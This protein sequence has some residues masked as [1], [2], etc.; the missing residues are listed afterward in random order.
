MRIG[1]L[2]D[3]HANLEALS[4]VLRELERSRVDQ[5]VCLGDVV[6]YHAN[7]NECVELLARSG[8]LTLAGNHDR[9]A[10]GGLDPEYFGAVAKRALFWTRR[11][12]SPEHARRLAELRVFGWLDRRTCLVHAALHPV[13]NDRYHLST[14]TRVAASFAK[15]HSGEIP[16][17]L[18]FFGH[19]HRPCVQASDG[20]H[21]REI[22]I[23]PSP[24]PLDLDSGYYL[25]NPG[26]VGQPR[27]GD[28]RAA[29]AVF[30]DAAG[31]LEFKSASYDH[32]LCL[33]KAEAAG[34]LA[35]VRPGW[36]RLLRVFGSR[37][38]E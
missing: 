12:L 13:P 23:G 5:V 20:R 37:K 26:S 31:T 1:L 34:L 25:V 35:P 24:V 36:E 11:A 10:V 27:T 33:R 2:S 17:R 22:A 19:T 18:C 29:F 28:A 32:E 38:A 7:P 4:A 16:A 21:V 9:A 6:G 8:A 3:V 30:D 14:S 15:L